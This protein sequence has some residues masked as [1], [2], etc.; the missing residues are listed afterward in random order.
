MKKLITWIIALAIVVLPN[1]WFADVS[2]SKIQKEM[3]IARYQVDQI[4]WVSLIRNIDNIFIE[5]ILDDDL[6]LIQ[7]LNINLDN[8]FSKKTNID[9]LTHKETLYKYLYIRTTY[10]LNYR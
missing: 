4:Y 6:E 3:V 2:Q 8:Y 9:N 1:V 7:K 10:E 5:Q